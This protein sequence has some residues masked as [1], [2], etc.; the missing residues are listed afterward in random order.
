MC[1]RF[2]RWTISV[3]A[4]ALAVGFLSTAWTVQGQDEQVLETFQQGIRYYQAG[5]YAQAKEAFGSVLAQEP[6][7]S[8]LL[9]MRTKAEIGLFIEMKDNDLLSADAAKLLEMMW[10]AAQE[11]KRQVTGADKL[12]DDFQSSDMDVY[13]AAR[14]KL[15]GHGPYA[16]PYL[17]PLVAMKAPVDDMAKAQQVNTTVGRAAS[18]LGQMPSDACLPLIQ[19]LQGSDNPLVRERTAAVLG[20]LGDRR[21]VPALLAAVVDAKSLQP[22][23]ETA[24]NALKMIVGDDLGALGSASDQ[25]ISMGKAYFLEDV[26][27]VGFTYGV[28]ANIW[29]WDADAAEMTQKLIC[30]QVPQYL[31]YQRM[32]SEVALAGL[33][34]DA[35]NEELLALLA[36]SQVR[37]LALCEAYKTADVADDVKADATARAAELAVEV[38]VVLHLL[39]SSVVG[40]ALELTI[41]AGDRTASLFLTQTMGA[42]LDDA[43]PAAPDEKTVA[44]LVDA[45]NSGDKDVRYNAAINLVKS[46]P[47]GECGAA[48]Q[49]IGV[50]S[51]ALR[52]AAVSNALV[53][54]DDLNTRNA[55][56][57]VLRGEGLTTTESRVEDGV[58]QAVL[59]MQP[60]VD[61]VFISS[62]TSESVFSRALAVVRSDPRT[63]GAPL[64]VIV[65]P[66]QD[67][68]DVSK[69][70][71]IERVLTVDHIRSAVLRPF[72]QEKVFQE[73]KTAFTEE[74]EALVLKAAE[75]LKA[76]DPLNTQ[77][78]LSRLEPSLMVALKGYSEEV[79]LAVLAALAEFGSAACVDPM[80]ALVAGDGSVELKVAACGAMASVLKRA[81]AAASEKATGILKGALAGDV[82]ELR[83]AA[84]EALGAAR[85][86]A[87]EVLS[88]VVTE[89]LGEK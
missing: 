79:S 70:A 50:L 67:F 64:F 49:T 41:E 38:P 84:A 25:Y 55:L 20:E 47:T 29:Q 60:S 53:I 26:Q 61:I 14:V 77:Y 30:E 78:D 63:K 17:L 23:V 5:E 27:R 76:V 44:A 58:I 10:R 81:G 11:T 37:Q 40:R 7:V 1:K 68:V 72:I 18:L 31:Y 65:D 83:E 87:E 74:E 73:R 19:A 46:C 62:N 51:A 56:I 86:S 36:A 3:A 57:S 28:T 12:I 69:E 43:G 54:M 80:A 6:D 8:T 85:L 32:A 15:L 48:E 4:V 22:T 42:K 24:L 59:E 82:Q 71:G 66:A 75:A 34:R 33:A 21:A 52:A 16:V 2:D 9:Q 88:L 35:A 45:L 39:P 89:G 13:I